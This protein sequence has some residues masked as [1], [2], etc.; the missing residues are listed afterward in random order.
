MHTLL[1]VFTLACAGFALGGCASSHDRL[2]EARY[3]LAPH[4]TLPLA[5]RLSITY[6]GAEDSRC[7]DNARCIWAGRLAHRFT[8]RVGGVAQAFYLV[9]GQP[10]Y[11]SPALRGSR[12]E[13]DHL[14]PPPPRGMAGAAPVA[15]PVTFNMYAQ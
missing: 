14:T 3:T 13:L 10:G 4:Q 1:R 11:M 7:P 9:R 15:Y 6:E 5:E 8:M 2:P 12:I